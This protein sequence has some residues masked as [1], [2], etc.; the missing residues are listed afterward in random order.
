MPTRPHSR[1]KEICMVELSPSEESKPQ[2]PGTGAPTA[3]APKVPAD[4][5]E[6]RRALCY[7]QN[8]QQFRSLNEQMN[9]VPTLSITVTGGL[10]FAAGVTQNIDPQIRFGLL[11]FAVVCN[12]FLSCVAFRIRSVMDS[13]LNRLEEFEPAAYA[14]APPHVVSMISMY[15]ILMLMASA[16]SLMGAYAF[17]WPF[18]A[19]S[20]TVK[21]V[22]F[23]V[24][25]IIVLSPLIGSIVRGAC[26]RWCKQ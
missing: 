6:A 23:A 3:E 2:A 14:K 4:G 1:Q 8:F 18:A 16:L 13:Y 20:L 21:Y 15:C 11:I 7:Q 5:T 10:W 12:V 19:A 22:T 26:K 24:L 25:G 17:F 9:R